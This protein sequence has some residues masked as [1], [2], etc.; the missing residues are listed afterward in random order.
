MEAVC[1]QNRK[2]VYTSAVNSDILFE[3][4]FADIFQ[5]FQMSDVIEAKCGEF[6]AAVL[7][8]DMTL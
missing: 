2:Y 4:Y 1:L 6:V 5:S 7:K 3:I 8:I